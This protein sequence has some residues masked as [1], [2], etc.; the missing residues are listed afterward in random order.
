MI[1]GGP[2]AK[3][4][5]SATSV[6][7]LLV[8]PFYRPGL[9]TIERPDF[10]TIDRGQLTTKLF[11]FTRTKDAFADDVMI[12]EGLIIVLREISWNVNPNP[13]RETVFVFFSVQVQSV[14]LKFEPQETDESDW[15]AV[16]SLRI[17]DQLYEADTDGFLICAV[18]RV[19]TDHLSC[20]GEI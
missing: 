11:Q 1:Q 13:V 5:F 18:L 8:T 9:S 16:V 17:V 10:N 20:C 12:V 19:V 2:P 7:L 14:P 4:V 3:S 6:L 15:S